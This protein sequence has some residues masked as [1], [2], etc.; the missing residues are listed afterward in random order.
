[1]ML[2]LDPGIP[3]VW[4]DPQ[5]LQL[6]VDPV[7]AV[8]PEVSQGVARLVAD[9]ASGVPEA[10]F[11]MLAGTR[12]IRAV[13]TER[14]LA[15]LRPALLPD[16]PPPPAPERCVLVLG[17]GPLAG[18]IA[19]LLDELGLRTPD[20]NA[21]ELVV[22]VADRVVPPADHRH[23]LRHDVP[24]LPVVTGETAVTLGPFVVP[25]ASACLHCAALHERDA[26]PAW[27]VIAAQLG[28]LPAPVTPPL[29]AATAVLQAARMVAAALLGEAEPG[30]AL[31]IA[32]D[33]ELLSERTIA[34]HPECR[35]AAPPGSDWAP[36][37]ET[38]A[39]EPTSAG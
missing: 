8:V 18:A 26:D 10:G 29:R 35:C 2:R 7:V 25:G 3:L 37:D 6:G 20:P 12:G 24:H 31:R 13:R 33:G 32:G 34:P 23:W 21:P 14:L 9:L 28:A 16:P 4:R 36:A 11:R 5:T 17:A 22:L 39:P 15:A 19:R 38:A 30:R 1:M 27:P